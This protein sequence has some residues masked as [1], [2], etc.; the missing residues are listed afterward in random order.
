MRRLTRIKPKTKKAPKVWTPKVDFRQR[1][2]QEYSKMDFNYQSVIRYKQDLLNENTHTT[3][4]YN[5]KLSHS[6]VDKL[7]DKLVTRKSIDTAIAFIE[8]D[9]YHNNH[10]HFAWSCTV[11][12]TREQISNT[13]RIREKYVRDVKPILDVNDAISYFTKRI[14]A[15]GS[16]HNLYIYK[17]NT[18]ERKY[19]INEVI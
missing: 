17:T 2:I 5:Q 7:M 13:M 11:P 6:Y 14:E 8:Q 1:R 18:N 19:I 9:D 16:Y 12:L 10:L 4:V 3:K 15:R